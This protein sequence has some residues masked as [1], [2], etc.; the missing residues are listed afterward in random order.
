MKS[1]YMTEKV[2][3]AWTISIEVQ[4]FPNENKKVNQLN[5]EQA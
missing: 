1:A 3:F 4:H 2:D 5:V